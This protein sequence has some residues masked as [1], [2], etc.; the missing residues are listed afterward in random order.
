M[1]D[2]SPVRT[3]IGCRQRE[4]QYHLI[5]VVLVGDADTRS[6][7]LDEHRRLP[8]RGAWLHR[9]PRCWDLAESRRGFARA[10]KGPVDTTDL[11]EQLNRAAERLVRRDE[12]GRQQTNHESGSE[13]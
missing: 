7:T 12:S 10:F 13:I 2:R 9:D 3:C 4:D 11:R 5:R 8:G 1:R 6:V